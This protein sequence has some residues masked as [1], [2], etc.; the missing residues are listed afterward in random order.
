[1]QKSVSVAVG[2]IVKV[3]VM[4]KIKNKIKIKRRE[5]VVVAW[6][7]PIPSSRP[8]YCVSVSRYLDC[9]PRQESRTSVTVSDTDARNR[10]NL[11][12]KDANGTHE[13]SVGAKI[14]DHASV[15]GSP[16]PPKK[17]RV[18]AP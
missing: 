17:R 9:L 1:M 4:A 11:Y 3:A 2:A 15:H 8:V 12:W 6:L 13:I 18:R 14:V 10:D 5:T 16:P 7:G